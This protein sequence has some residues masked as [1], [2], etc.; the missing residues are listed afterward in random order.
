MPAGYRNPENY[1]SETDSEDRR[2][3]QKGL[4]PL[5]SEINYQKRLGRG[6]Q[7]A[8]MSDFSKRIQVKDKNGKVKYMKR[9]KQYNKGTMPFIDD[10]NS[11]TG[12]YEGSVNADLVKVNLK[13]KMAKKSSSLV[14]GIYYTAGDPMKPRKT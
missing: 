9:R 11:F 10:S 3:K 6:G 7:V 2:K 5:R 14:R 12:T 4:L 13:S 8:P 1:I